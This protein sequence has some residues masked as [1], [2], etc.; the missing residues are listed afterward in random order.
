MKKLIEYMEIL[1]A[2]TVFFILLVASYN[3]KADPVM[4]PMNNNGMPNMGSDGISGVNNAN[5]G[6]ISQIGLYNESASNSNATGIA[7]NGVNITNNVPNGNPGANA[8]GVQGGLGNDNSSGSTAQLRL[9]NVGAN[10]WRI[11]VNTPQAIAP[12]IIGS[13][14]SPLARSG[15]ASG[16]NGAVSAGISF[17]WSERNPDCVR[18]MDVT[19]WQT[20]NMPRTACNRMIVGESSEENQEAIKKSGDLCANAG[21]VAAPVQTSTLPFV[22]TPAL[23]NYDPSQFVTKPELRKQLDNAHRLGVMK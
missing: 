17:G 10:T 3:A 13:E 18:A 2:V 11:P 21:Y 14:C 7:P 15:G 19:R 5:R 6:N 4:P 23:N 22:A 12:L 1:T 9:N 8:T 20:L 16:G